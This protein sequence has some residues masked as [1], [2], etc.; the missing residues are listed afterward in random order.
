MLET[1]SD[2]NFYFIALK[3]D[4]ENSQALIL[5]KIFLELL[6]QETGLKFHKA[7]GFGTRKNDEPYSIDKF[8]TRNRTVKCWALAA[9]NVY[10]IIRTNTTGNSYDYVVSW[11]KNGEKDIETLA[12]SSSMS[13]G[14]RIL[15]QKLKAQL[16]KMNLE[17]SKGIR[18]AHELGI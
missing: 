17:K 1:I 6:N 16:K 9:L 18:L 5:D 12:E 2:P 13:S 10:I 15:I 7:P 11:E 3:H 8:N 4:F 14:I